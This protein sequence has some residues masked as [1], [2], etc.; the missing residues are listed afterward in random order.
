MI[1]GDYVAMVFDRF[2]SKWLVQ[3]TGNS[4]VQSVISVIHNKQI[5]V[6][7]RYIFVVLGHNQLHMAERAV[8][9]DMFQELI[10]LIRDLSPIARIFVSALLPR[11][12]D[13]AMVK[14]LIVKFNRALSVVIGKIAKRDERV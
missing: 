7:R 12:V 4:M 9:G 13:N 5:T 2:N 6:D 14:P 1:I 10:G 3:V 11:P 8:V